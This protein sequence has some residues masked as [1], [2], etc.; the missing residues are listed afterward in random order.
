MTADHKFSNRLRQSKLMGRFIRTF[1]SKDDD[2]SL[3]RQCLS[4]LATHPFRFRGTIQN[5]VG[6]TI[7]FTVGGVQA[8]SCAPLKAL[9]IAAFGYMLCWDSI[10]LTGNVRKARAAYLKIATAKSSEEVPD[11]AKRE[12]FMHILCTATCLLIFILETRGMCVLARS[13]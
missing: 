13:I 8:S 5:C 9:Y 11:E 2:R 4:S 7:A 6:M 1:G 12:L 3:V 10:D